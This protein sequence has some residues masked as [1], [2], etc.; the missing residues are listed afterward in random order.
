[1]YEGDFTVEGDKQKLVDVMLGIY[2]WA[3]IRSQAG[4]CEMSKSCGTPTTTVTEV[5][6]ECQR[7]RTVFN[8]FSAAGLLPTDYHGNWTDER[9]ERQLAGLEVPLPQ[10]WRWEEKEW[11]VDL[12]PTVDEHGWEYAIN[13]PPTG[14]F[15]PAFGN[16]VSWHPLVSS[17]DLVRRRRHVRPR[18]HLAEVSNRDTIVALLRNNREHV[19]PRE[20]FADLPAIIESQF[21]EAT[22]NIFHFD[23]DQVLE[24]VPGQEE[25]RSALGKLADVAQT[26]SPKSAWQSMSSRFSAAAKVGHSGRLRS[27]SLERRRSQPSPAAQPAPAA[28]TMQTVTAGASGV[29]AV[30]VE[31]Y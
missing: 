10:G 18:A 26:H 19:F 23:L 11:E 7:R 8:N 13:W 17:L 15:A 30:S 22:P 27:S 20:Y 25:L 31:I 21:M 6:V 29:A 4:G 28:A 2:S 9:M 16:R 12:S 1:M 5:V 24:L 14:F 3:L